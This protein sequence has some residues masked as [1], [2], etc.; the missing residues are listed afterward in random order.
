MIRRVARFARAHKVV[1]VASGEV[2]SAFLAFH[3][4]ISLATAGVRINGTGNSRLLL[5]GSE[6]E[7]WQALSTVIARFLSACSP[8]QN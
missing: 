5:R 8:R 3:C 6:R 7:E 4:A 2:S 1:T